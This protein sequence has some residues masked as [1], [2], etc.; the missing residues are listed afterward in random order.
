ML[1]LIEGYM[2][3]EIGRSISSANV[4]SMRVPLVKAGAAAIAPLLCD[5]VSG[6]VFHLSYD[7]LNPRLLYDINV[8]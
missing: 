4:S 7:V 2:V 8:S 6:L 5:T 3:H 1:C